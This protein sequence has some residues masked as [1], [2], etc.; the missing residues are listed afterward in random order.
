MKSLLFSTQKSN[1]STVTMELE[2]SVVPFSVLCTVLRLISIQLTTNIMIA[3]V[4]QRPR[5]KPLCI[6]GLQ[7]ILFDLILIASVDLQTIL[8]A[9]KN[10]Q[11][12]DK[13]DIA[14]E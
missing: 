5:M 10:F 7:T 9:S 1:F 11:Q 2:P 4:N 14:A 8:A 13:V 6:P 12:K 3:N